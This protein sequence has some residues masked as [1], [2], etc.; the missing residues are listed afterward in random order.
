MGLQKFH[1]LLLLLEQNSVLLFQVLLLC[2]LGSA[3]VFHKRLAEFWIARH[4]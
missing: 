4:L 3:G 2:R 1:R